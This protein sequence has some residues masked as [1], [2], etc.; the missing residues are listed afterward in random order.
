METAFCSSQPDGKMLTRSSVLPNTACQAL[1]RSVYHS[2]WCWHFL[3]LWQNWCRER[4]ALA[5]I[6]PSP[7]EPAQLPELLPGHAS[8]DTAHVPVPRHV[9]KDRQQQQC[10]AEA[11][12]ATSTAQLNS[13]HQQACGD[14]PGLRA[15]PTFS[16]RQDRQVAPV[17]VAACCMRCGVEQSQKM[18]DCR[19]HPA[20]LPDPGPFLYGPEWHACRAAQHGRGDP[21]CYVRQGHYFPGHAVQ[22]TGLLNATVDRVRLSSP[23]DSQ[24]QP[25]PRTQ[26]PIP[27]CRP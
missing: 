25:Q 2:R 20:L 21:G 5:P 27:L 24:M 16:Y 26:L 13:T 19:F 22:G 1:G 6:Q 23:T 15:E 17:A 18:S 10:T 14:H 7:Q 4:R 9:S 3:T 8:P 11:C 12:M